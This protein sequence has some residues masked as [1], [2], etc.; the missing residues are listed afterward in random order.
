MAKNLVG[1]GIGYIQQKR[2]A[3]RQALIDAGIDPDNLFPDRKSYQPKDYNPN[4]DNDIPPSVNDEWKKSR[5]WVASRIDPLVLDLDGDGIETL[6]ISSTTHV[7]FDSDGEKAN[8]E[9]RETTLGCGVKTG[10]GWVK[11]DDGLLVLDRNGNGTIDNGNELFGEK[12][13]CEARET[14]LGC[15]TTGEVANLNFRNLRMVA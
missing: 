8:G 9:A 6:G 12:V 13:N 10:A 15:G 1:S 5:D 2:D 11:S 7:M 3:E 4:E 14:T